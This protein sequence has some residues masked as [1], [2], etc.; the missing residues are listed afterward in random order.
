[1]IFVVVGVFVLIILYI[2]G[3]NEGKR[4]KLSQEYE[5]QISQLK[6][7]MYNTKMIAQRFKIKRKYK[8][9]KCQVKFK[10]KS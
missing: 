4:R 8:F 10:V 1:M 6:D 5:G 7:S 2:L 9:F 3:D